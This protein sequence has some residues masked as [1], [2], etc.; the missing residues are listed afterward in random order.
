[1]NN[2]SYQIRC[3]HEDET[4]SMIRL[5][6][7][8]F[9]LDFD[10][11]NRVFHSDPFFDITHKR[12]LVDNSG[13]ILSCLTLIPAEL[14][15]G[16]EQSPSTVKM[17]GIAGVCTHPECRGRGL[18]AALLTDSVSYAAEIGYAATALTS[19]RPDY[20]INLGWKPYGSAYDWCAPVGHF[21]AAASNDINIRLLTE[22]D[23]QDYVKQIESYYESYVGSKVSG[24]FL[25]SPNRWKAI[26]TLTV[27]RRTLIAYDQNGV[28]AGYLAYDL[29]RTDLGVTV[30]VHEI[31]SE[32]PEFRLSLLSFFYSNRI[33]EFIAGRSRRS[34]VAELG[35]IGNPEIR[36]TESP[37]VYIR[38][39]DSAQ[40]YLEPILKQ[41]PIFLSYPD[42][43]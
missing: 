15:L 23:Y 4:I 6:A 22:A 14:Y 8:S 3:L 31:V 16:S 39:A 40:S 9:G 43:F 1:M 12:V 7:I 33:G 10:N 30:Y 13:N 21:S 24:T 18:A 26:S 34:E 2:I 17:A 42:M 41:L 11:A 32:L 29:R 19:E 5:M 25:R 35:L 38:I 36:V 28:F 27:G 37:S 20:Y